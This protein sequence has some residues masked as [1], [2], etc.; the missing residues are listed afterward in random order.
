[1]KNYKIT[2]LGR[3]IDISYLP[4]KIILQVILASSI[5]YYIYS[6]EAML[7]IWGCFNLF[8]VWAI[9]RELDP[10][11]DYAAI[12]S[13]L[14][15]GIVFFISPINS[16]FLSLFWLLLILRSLNRSTGLKVLFSDY[17]FISILSTLVTIQTKNPFFLFMNIFALLWINFS[18][19]EKNT[20]AGLIVNFASL[21]WYYF[22]SDCQKL[23]YFSYSGDIIYFL[24]FTT[25]LIFL[26]YVSLEKP[27]ISLEDV[28]KVVINH[29][30]LINAQIFFIIYTTY[31]I[32]TEFLK[33]QSFL[34][35]TIMFGS[36]IHMAYRKINS[37]NKIE[38]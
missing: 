30:F 16:S 21:F 25:L 11:H 27:P 22:I 24:S 13:V 1:M 18:R 35:A 8:L 19:N 38:E 10:D 15:Y 5:L 3:P 17:I 36:I 20:Y 23:V 37:L 7:S 33:N 2:A 31:I 34:L 32:H 14:V 28:G 12:I 29:K 4:N 6:K 26:I 9:N